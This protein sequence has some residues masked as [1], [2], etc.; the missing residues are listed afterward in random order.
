MQPHSSDLRQRIVDLYEQGEGSIRGL[1]ERFQVSPDCVFK[2]IKR[3]R[4]TGSVSPKPHAGGPQ[5]ALGADH[6]QVLLQLIEED[7]DA[8]LPQLAQRLEARTLV[9]VS[10]ST[11]SRTLTK[12]NLTRKKKALKPAKPIVKKINSSV[13]TTGKPSGT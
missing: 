2:L 9:K 8:T 13:M 5:P 7:N 4:A 11:I 3:Y 6:H 1:A 10:P 12:L